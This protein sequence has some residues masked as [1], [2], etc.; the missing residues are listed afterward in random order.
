MRIRFHGCLLAI[1]TLVFS[2]GTASAQQSAGTISGR[3]TDKENQAGV[4]GATVQAVTATGSPVASAVTDADG[5]FR[6]SASSGTY[7]LVVTMLGYQTHRIENVRV[8]S[9]EAS[10]VSAALTSEAVV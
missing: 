5:E 3:I 1:L 6:L 8:V 4:A 9:G 7:S 2:V 10:L